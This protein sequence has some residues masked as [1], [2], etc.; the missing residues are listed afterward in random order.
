MSKRLKILFTISI[1]LNVVCAG[2]VGGHYA[3]KAY[4]WN[5]LYDGLEDETRD[6]VKEVFESQRQENKNVRQMSKQHLRNIM[7]LFGAEAFD[8]DAFRAAVKEWKILHASTIDG[9]TDMMV[10]LAGQ[11]TQE[12]RQH[13]SKRLVRIFKGR[14]P[15][16]DQKEMKDRAFRGKVMTE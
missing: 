13:I 9:K 2:F 4:R 16:R 10:E 1:L 11:L 8:E 6:R 3:K 5:A 12:E 15:K 14:K 7:D